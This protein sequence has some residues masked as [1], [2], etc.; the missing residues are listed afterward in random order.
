MKALLEERRRRQKHTDD[1]EAFVPS[2]V[3]TVG[4]TVGDG[5]KGLKGLVE[6][7]KRKSQAGHGS[8]KRRRQ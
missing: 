3:R 6:S 2:S 4:G 1:S 7:V 8:G 5:D